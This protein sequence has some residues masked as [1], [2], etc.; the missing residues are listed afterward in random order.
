M[1]VFYTLFGNF[2]ILRLTSTLAQCMV[3]KFTT[4]KSF[5]VKRPLKVFYPHLHESCGFVTHF[6]NSQMELAKWSTI[7]RLFFLL[8]Y[9]KIDNSFCF[10]SFP[11]QEIEWQPLCIFTAS[12]IGSVWIFL[13]I[14][15]LFSLSLSLP[16][17]LL[18]LPPGQ[19]HLFP[20]FFSP[21]FSLS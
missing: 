12:E 3:L 16:P 10:A 9:F 21:D 20:L 15:N 7:Q 19:H 14:T 8:T 17:P 4:V 6:E 18:F 13:N 2:I 11:V 1:F 5:I